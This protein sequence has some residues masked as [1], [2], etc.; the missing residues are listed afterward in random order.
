[1]STQ[2]LVEYDLSNGTRVLVNKIE[3]QVYDFHLTRLN[4]MKHNFTWTEILG[5]KDAETAT[6]LPRES[7]TQ[8]ELEALSV[9]QQI[10]KDNQ[11]I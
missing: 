9:F 4:G 5:I 10:K 1:M 7:F 3:D 6:A 8:E 2:F 11:S